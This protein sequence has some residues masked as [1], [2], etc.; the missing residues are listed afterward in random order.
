MTRSK[1]LGLAAVLLT[2]AGIAIYYLL[3]IPAQ[4]KPG[5]VTS[6]QRY[7]T[8]PWQAVNESFVA[9]DPSRPS[10]AYNDFDGLPERTLDAE[11]WRPAARATPGPLLIY[12]HGF[13]SFRREGL[14]LQ[15]FLASHGYTVVAA[16]YPLT[17]LYAPDGPLMEDVV[18]QPGDISFLIDTILAR[19]AD[20]DDV[21]HATIDPQRIA[22]AGVSLGGLTSTLAAFHRELRDTR[23]AAAVSIAGPASM[24]TPEYYAGSK[25]PFLMIYG[26]ADAIVPFA[27][28]VLPITDMHANAVL[29]SLVGASHAAFAQPAST[30]MRFIDNPD[31]VGCRAVTEQMDMDRTMRSNAI[32][33]LASGDAIGVDADVEFNVC[34]GDLVPVAMQ[35]ARQH[36]FTTLATHAFLEGVFAQEPDAAAARTYL[37]TTLAAE[38]AAEVRVVTPVITMPP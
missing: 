13:M 5:G 37:L 10:Q 27:D 12:S 24:F 21:L 32:R 34:T 2:L 7:Q 20:P 29:V 16:D 31:S 19:N 28:N 4:P 6:Q 15:Q 35:A 23:I 33:A 38:N 30:L 9:V 3:N 18:N 14:Y 26:T 22:V 1:K 36:M 17:G 25:L 8:G 11:I